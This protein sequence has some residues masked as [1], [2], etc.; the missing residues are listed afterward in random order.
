MAVRQTRPHQRGAALL[1]SLIML[2]A[3]L[4]LGAATAEIAVQGEYGARNQRDRMLAYQG[5]QAGLNDALFDIVHGSRAELFAASLTSAQDKENDSGFPHDK[6]CHADGKRRGLCGADLQNL[7]WKKLELSQAG[8]AVAEYGSFSHRRFTQEG[9]VL[10]TQ[11]PRYA[12]ELIQLPPPEGRAG[13]DTQTGTADKPVQHLFRITAIGFG[14]RETTQV[15][16]QMLIRKDAATPG[17]AARAQVL[18]WKEISG[19]KRRSADR[20]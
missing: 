19:W 18:S 5:A 7:N 3:I 20:K 13:S 12:I 11:P 2:T 8:G 14:N 15:V 6:L 10:P 1:V 17:R 9:G 16:L 4:L